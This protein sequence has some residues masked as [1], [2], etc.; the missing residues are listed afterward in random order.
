MRILRI[1]YHN[2]IRVLAHRGRDRQGEGSKRPC[3]GSPTHVV[4]TAG[5]L[6]RYRPSPALDGR[7]PVERPPCDSNKRHRWGD[8]YHPVASGI[9]RTEWFNRINTPSGFSSGYQMSQGERAEG[10]EKRILEL[11]EWIKSNYRHL[12]DDAVKVNPY[13]DVEKCI[14]Y[15][16]D[17]VKREAMSRFVMLP[18]MAKGYAESA[19]SPFFEKFEKDLE[20]ATAAQEK[21]TQAEFRTIISRSSKE[22]ASRKAAMD[23]FNILSKGGAPVERA[24]WVQALVKTSK[25][26]EQVAAAAIVRL[27]REGLVFESKPGFYERLVS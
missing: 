9:S 17:R 13:A 2:T 4:A 25:I 19:V 12:L 11:R 20:S 10:T 1:R 5:T 8:P 23:C 24:L 16:N 15:I 3:L 21:R 27:A 26:D 7:A 22:S 14:T 18:A 6:S